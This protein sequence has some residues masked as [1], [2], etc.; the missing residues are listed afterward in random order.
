MIPQHTVIVADNA[1]VLDE[2][3]D[4]QVDIH[5]AATKLEDQV[6]GE[7]VARLIVTREDGQQAFFFVVVRVSK[8]G[9]PSAE[10]IAKKPD[11][12]EVRRSVQ[13]YWK[14]PRS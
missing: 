2:Q 7:T 13:G 8:C 1:V 11:G 3:Q 10:V 5:L 9:R 14:A 12:A 6:G 4:R